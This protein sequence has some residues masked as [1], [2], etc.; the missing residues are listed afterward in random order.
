MQYP[1]VVS[2]DV[3]AVAAAFAVIS[4]TV[5][6]VWLFPVLQHGLSIGGL[7]ATVQMQFESGL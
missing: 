7:T 1:S 3:A 4:C 2:V 5:A 6:G